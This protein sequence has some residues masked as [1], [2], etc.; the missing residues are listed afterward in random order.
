MTSRP[1][2]GIRNNNP[3][4]IRRSVSKWRGKIQNPTDPEFEQFATLEYGLRA[5]F[6]ILQ[7]YI[8]RYRISTPAAIIA[9]WAPATENNTQKYIAYVSE[10]SKLGPNERLD[11][12]QKNALCR[13][14]YA[15]ARY[16]CG[17]EVS[18]GRIE[19]AYA[20]AFKN[21]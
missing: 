3:L 2:R 1:P 4:N 19:N 11:I 9:R 13:L 15:M 18:F 8:K 10:I 16:E 20:L 14:V 7:T 17:V 6:I 21:P 12:S 5:A